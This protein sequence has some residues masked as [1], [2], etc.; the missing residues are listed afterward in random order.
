ALA[1]A[2]AALPPSAE[3]GADMPWLLAAMFSGGYDRNAARW[4]RAV[5]AM[6][7]EGKE[8]AWALLAV[9]L[10]DTS[11]GIARDRI[12]A[13]VEADK[14]EEKIASRMLIAALAG[15]GRLDA[16]QAASLSGN[17]HLQLQSRS[18]WARVLAQAAALRQK[19]TV[20]L[21]AAVGMQARDWTQLPPEHLMAILAALRQVGLEPEARMI[22]AEAI[23]R[24]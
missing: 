23:T 17:L 1:R 6:D 14:S 19:G 2:A 20:A 18:R 15:L 21:L 16:D 9:G 4:V 11:A 10:P 3:A 22:A 12:D 7:G 8:R 5:D 13:F 24:L